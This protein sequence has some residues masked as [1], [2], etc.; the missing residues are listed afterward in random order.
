MP[1]SLFLL[2]RNGTYLRMESFL[3]VSTMAEA[4]LETYSSAL[5]GITANN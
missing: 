5:S 2:H 1:I 3:F 4:D